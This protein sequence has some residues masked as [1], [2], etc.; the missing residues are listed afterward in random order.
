MV[1][2]EDP[3]AAEFCRFTAPRECIDPTS[4]GISPTR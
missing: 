4:P 1:G 2:A 3:W